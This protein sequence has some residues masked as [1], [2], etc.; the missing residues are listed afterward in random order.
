LHH[1]PVSVGSDAHYPSRVAQAHQHSEE[2]LREAGIREVRIWRH[3]EPE[4][5]QF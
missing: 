2:I 4:A 1:T 5:Y 3:M